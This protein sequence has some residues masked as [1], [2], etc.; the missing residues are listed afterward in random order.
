M[1]NNEVMMNE[2]IVVEDEV[3]EK[4]ARGNTGLGILIGSVITAGLIYGSKKAKV[5]VAKAKM[6]HAEKKA[7]KSE[8]EGDS[9]S[10]E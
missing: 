6:N 1:E 2:E 9:E 8:A 3:V 7:A 4:E 10:D 5:L